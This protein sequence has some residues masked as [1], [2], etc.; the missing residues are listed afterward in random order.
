MRWNYGV[1]A[2]ALALLILLVGIA[3]L[4]RAPQPAGPLP[5][6]PLTVDGPTTIRTTDAHT[7][8]VAVNTSPLPFRR[9]DHL[10]HLRSNE[11]LPRIHESFPRAHLELYEKD[12]RIVAPGGAEVITLALT[13]APPRP[14]S[15][16]K[17]VRYTGYE[18]HHETR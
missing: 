10:F 6:M 2:G 4:H 5:G 3:T 7:I 11:T 9:A 1:T 8:E 15:T 14:E 18:L 13:Q 12:L 17:S 16:P